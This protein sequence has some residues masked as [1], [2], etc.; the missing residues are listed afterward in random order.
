MTKLKEIMKLHKNGC[1]NCISID[2]YCEELSQEDVL[3]MECYQ[4]IKNRAV[5]HFCIIGGGMHQIE[6]CIALKKEEK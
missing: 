6:L 1:C 4:E 5:D 2:G 3:A